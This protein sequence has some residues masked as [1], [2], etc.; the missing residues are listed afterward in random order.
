MR[1]LLYDRE[2]RTW[3]SAAESARDCF[4]RSL[5]HAVDSVSLLAVGRFKNAVLHAKASAL[6]ATASVA[7]KT[8]A[9]TE[10]EDGT[11]GWYLDGEL[12]AVTR[13]RP[14]GN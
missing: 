12:I 7:A 6:F 13:E 8:V 10:S 4:A 11:L 3:R 9:K 2:T 14:V 1:V 5:R